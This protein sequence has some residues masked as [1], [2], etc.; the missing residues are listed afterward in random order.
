MQ[1]AVVISP[2]AHPTLC[3]EHLTT[4]HKQTERIEQSDAFSLRN[5][6]FPGQKILL[7]L[8]D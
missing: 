7:D 5:W 8:A 1:V 3:M 6:S 4:W 2:G